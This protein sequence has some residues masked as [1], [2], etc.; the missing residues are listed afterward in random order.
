MRPLHALLL[1]CCL[2]VCER[3]SWAAGPPDSFATVQ[4]ILAQCQAAYYRLVD[5][6]GTL[7]REMWEGGTA[8]RLDDIEVLFRKPTFLSLR[9]QSGLYK[10]TELLT[11]PGW[12]RGNLFI[13]LGDWFSFISVS[14]PPVDAAEPFVPMLK[15]VS[16]WLTA[17]AMLAQRSPLD[18]SLRLVEVRLTDPTLAEGQVLLIIPSFL[19]PLRENTVAV[20]EFVIERGTGVPVELVLRGAGGE[21]RQRLTY[22]DLQVNVG[23]SMQAFEREMDTEG[24]QPLPQAE[25]ELDVRGFIQNWQH[26][27]GEITDYT[28]VWIAQERQGEQLV[29]SQASFKFRKPFDLYIEWGADGGRI[30]SAL[31][32]QGWNEGRM[33]VRA[34]VWGVP[35][36]G[37]LAPD[38]YWA[39]R[40]YHYPLSEF[41]I[42]RVVERSQEQLLRAWL[43]GELTVR[44]R[45]VQLHEGSPCYVL[46]FLFPASRWRE[47]PHARV[48]TYWDIAQRV[49]VRS[50]AFDW[51]DHLDEHYEFQQLR[52]NVALSDSEF[53]ATNP[54]SGFLLFRHAPRLDRFLTGRE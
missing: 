39:R 49:P 41:G 4:E 22:T 52:F 47:Y 42:N 21:V 13:K 1:A 43:Q 51:A 35:L 14:M 32:R 26:R 36:I 29:R 30:R 17:L 53:D 20:Y 5:Y 9:W 45:G 46:E 38:G 8:P 27:Y 34:V 50:E 40:G 31:L 48:V 12:N 6:R 10:G 25:A 2:L 28:G 15:D 33:R 37:D 24:F 44:F 18:P 3:P 19:I 54:A 7:H 16:E 11:R 23:V